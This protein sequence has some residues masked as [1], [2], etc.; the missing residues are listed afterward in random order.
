MA[1]SFKENIKNNKG[2]SLEMAIFMLIVIF[3]LCTILVTV[4]IMVFNQERKALND[5]NETV[6]LDGMGDEFASFAALSFAESNHTFILS[7][8][9]I[10]SDFC[11]RGEYTYT[12]VHGQEQVGYRYWL[13]VSQE[14]NALDEVVRY[15]LKVRDARE[16]GNVLLTV[17]VN[18]HGDIGSWKYA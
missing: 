1:Y 8:Y 13:F 18:N 14:R 5:M 9:A 2:L 4:G 17:T 16:N 12:D 11:K 7:R 3:G 6:L 10:D 15:E